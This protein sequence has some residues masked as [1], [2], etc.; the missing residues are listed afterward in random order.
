[1][2]ER[3]PKICVFTLG[4]KVN[5]YDS[6]AMLAVFRQAGFEVA[7]GLE[8][9]DAY[10]I[11]TC[12]VTAE[13]EKKSRQSIA[14]VR[15]IN[16]RA[17]IYICGCASQRDSAQFER[18]GVEYV[19]GTEGKI[20]LAHE[21]VAKLK[22]GTALPSADFS[23]SDRYEE[24]EGVVNLRTRHFIKVQDGCNNFCSY[25]IIPYLRGRSRS[26][27]VESIRAEL[28]GVREGV[29]EVVVTG[30]NLSA[31]GKER[32]GSLTELVQNLSD[33]DFRIR[34]GSIEANVIDREFLAATTRL[35][36][37]CPHFHLS[38]Q[39][40]DADV[41]KAMNRHYT[42]DEYIKKVELI[43][44]YYPNAGVTTD[45]IVGFPTETEAQFASCAEFARRVGFSDIHVFPYSSR[46]GTAAGKLKPLPPAVME[47]RVRV[48]TEL[49]K[50]LSH[51][52]LQRHI[53]E[54]CEVLFET[55][56]NDM[57]VGHTPNYIKVYSSSGE[58][59]SL[60]RVVAT[61]LYLD[62]ISAD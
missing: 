17:S 7:E 45:I 28:D 23:I 5:L 3:V 12:A 57:W 49:K 24:G 44:E 4:C 20:R 11:N 50:Q 29:K 30:I 9:A 52:F 59:G 51:D 41:L 10:V 37:F 47:S 46:G 55:C 38:L 22:D 14:R 40:G 18:D 56:E 16:D 53:G 62:G 21:I 13:A 43:R 19:G 42:P 27:S 25:C 15:K 2:S 6:D 60:K 32:G 58:R 36:A 61:G 26:R 8:Y 1:M 35:K 34:L 39:S 54:E 48:M 33:Y 31:Y